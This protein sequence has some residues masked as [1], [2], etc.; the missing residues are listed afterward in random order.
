MCVHCVYRFSFFFFTATS[1]PQFR[2][3]IYKSVCV[4]VRVRLR[5]APRLGYFGA[6]Q[7]VRRFYSFQSPHYLFLF[8]SLLFSLYVFT[9][10]F[11]RD[12]SE[13]PP[14]RRRHF[15]S[16]AVVGSETRRLS[17]CRAIVVASS[18]RKHFYFLKSVLIFP[19]GF[20]EFSR[21]TFKKKKKKK[22]SI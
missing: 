3:I 17:R 5:V 13:H 11:S 15:T 14:L 16:L 12:G 22:F 9:R 2:A 21:D 8:S 7:L 20:F 6:V 10:L 1:R 4:C 19:G 18:V